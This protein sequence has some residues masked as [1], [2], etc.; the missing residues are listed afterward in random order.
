MRKIAVVV[1]IIF[2]VA[3]LGFMA[4][5]RE[6][7]VHNGRTVYLRTAPVDPRDVFRG[8]YVALSYEIS[9]IEDNLLRDEL[10]KGVAWHD[11]GLPVYVVLT[12]TDG[13]AQVS[14]ASD[15]R[16]DG[17]LFIR[18]R[19]GGPRFPG[20]WVKY[21]IE[22][23]YVEQGA[24]KKLEQLFPKRGEKSRLE[25]EVKIGSGGEAV[26]IGYRVRR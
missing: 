18:G 19:L 3:V 23:F 15:R 5:G 20:I 25:M 14:Y 6:Y 10:K 4:G 9:S 22:S 21:G 24:G 17:G 8:D 13:V 26:L 16:P 2:Q 11:R 1:A 7:I 12:E